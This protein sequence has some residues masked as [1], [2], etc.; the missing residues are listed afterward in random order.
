MIKRVLYLGYYYK[1][2][3]KTKFA[4]FVNFAREKSG[5]SK[6][7]IYLEMISSSLKYNISLLEYFQFG[8]WKITENEKPN[9]A[10]TGFM[11]EYQ[12]KMN[13]KSCRKKLEDKTI[14]LET[15][16]PFV[17][18]SFATISQLIND[19]SLTNKL[20]SN[21]S[22]KVVL[23]LSTGQVGAEVKVYNIEYFKNK[24]LLEEM[25]EKN[26]DLVEEFVIQH[27]DLMKLSPTA[28]NTVRIFTQLTKDNKVEILGARLR[29]SVNSSVDNMAAGNLAASVDLHSGVV[30]REAVYSDI[31]KSTVE[32]HPITK[33]PIVGFTVPY[34]SQVL[35]IV[36]NAALHDTSNRSIGWDVAISETGPELIEGNHNWCKI[37]WQL[38]VNKGL[39][40]LLEKY[41]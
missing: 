37:L 39:K 11:Y 26:F 3:D 15:Y 19:N 36:N 16:A 40:P 13:P 10:G 35:D 9:W 33:V 34:W 20:L 30:D 29:I 14:F 32:V 6:L 41:L 23:K 8:F 17:K 31:T 27:P 1:E 18:R 2:L 7:R 12:L 28:L 24:S 25:K 21:P 38:P 4:K 5:K 22:G